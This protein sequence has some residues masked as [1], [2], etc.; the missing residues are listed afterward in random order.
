LVLRFYKT[1]FWDVLS[2]DF[3]SDQK[4]CVEMFDTGV[5]MGTG[6][7]AVFLQDSLNITNNNAK[8][9]Q[10]LKVDGKIGHVTVG[11]MNKHP[12]TADV[13]KTLNIMQGARYIE[14]CKRNPKQEKFY[15]SWLSRV[16]LN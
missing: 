9:Y 1:E 2:L 16:S 14:I 12:R 8:L 13:L 7:A 11:L 4:I 10:D 15:R 3:V 5:N 6:V